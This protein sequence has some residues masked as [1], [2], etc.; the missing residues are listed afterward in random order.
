MGLKMLESKHQTAL[1]KVSQLES[2]L[3]NFKTIFISVLHF[4]Q[5]KHDKK[6]RELVYQGLYVA[7]LNVLYC[8]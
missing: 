3:N 7:E 2:K 1:I 4:L 6:L 8:K 5:R